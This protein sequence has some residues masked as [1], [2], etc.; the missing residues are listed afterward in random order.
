MSFL[1]LI[2]ALVIMALVITGLFLLFKTLNK[3]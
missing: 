3:K 2:G 1:D